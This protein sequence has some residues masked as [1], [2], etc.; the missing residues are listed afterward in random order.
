MIPQN[1]RDSFTDDGQPVNDSILCPSKR[2]NTAGSAN[3]HATKGDQKLIGE[4]CDAKNVEFM[5]SILCE[6]AREGLV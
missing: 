2:S 5:N 4:L 3:A 1:S 6:A